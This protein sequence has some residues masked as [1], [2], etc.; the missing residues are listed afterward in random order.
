MT[1][2]KSYTT[3]FGKSE[4]RVIVSTG[5]RNQVSVAKVTTLRRPFYKD[6]ASFENAIENYKD[7]NVKLYLELISLGFIIEKSTLVSE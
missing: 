5:N 2:Y 4:W 1:T 7:K 6:F 3:T